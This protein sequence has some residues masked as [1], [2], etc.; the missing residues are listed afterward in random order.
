MFDALLSKG[1]SRGSDQ[2]GGA[3]IARALSGLSVPVND[4]NRAPALRSGAT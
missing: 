2:G 3:G 1:G 4:P